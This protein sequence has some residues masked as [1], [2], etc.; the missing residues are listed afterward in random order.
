MADFIGF[1]K[2]KYSQVVEYYPYPANSWGLTERIREIFGSKHISVFD[3]FDDVLKN[4]SLVICTYPQT[5][6]SNAMHS[7]VPV[8]LLLNPKYW[9]FDPGFDDLVEELK[10]VKILFTNPQ[11]AADHL[12]S[13]VFD[14]EGWW[15]SNEVRKVRDRFFY[16]CLQLSGNGTADWNEFLQCEAKQ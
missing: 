13:I 4:S 11:L 8:I 10:K 1:C 16:E 5:T 7:G 9:E 15:D 2:D 6:F 12:D 3:H 14:I